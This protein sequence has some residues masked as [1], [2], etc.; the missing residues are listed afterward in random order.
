MDMMINY[1]ESFLIPEARNNE[2]TEFYFFSNYEQ[3]EISNKDFN[4]NQFFHKFNEQDVTFFLSL[5]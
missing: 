1:D 3:V 5:F 2:H 4:V